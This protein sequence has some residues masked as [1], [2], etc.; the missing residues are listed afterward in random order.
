MRNSVELEVTLLCGTVV[1]IGKFRISWNL[2]YPVQYDTVNI[3]SVTVLPSFHVLYVFSDG[4]TTIAPVPRKQENGSCGVQP[5][6]HQACRKR[7]RMLRNS[8]L[9][10]RYHSKGRSVE[11]ASH[12]TESAS[13]TMLPSVRRSRWGRGIILDGS[14]SAVTCCRRCLQKLTRSVRINECTVD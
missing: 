2:D 1:E 3:V 7:F 4:K 10:Y 8:K 12:G 11:D 13:A 5:L 9:W 14:H 6:E